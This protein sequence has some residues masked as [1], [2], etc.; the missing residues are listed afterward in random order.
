MR[1]LACL[2]FILLLSTISCAQLGNRYFHVDTL[3]VSTSARTTTYSQEWEF[4]TIYADTVDIM[5]KVGAPDIA[6]WASRD[7]FLV[8]QGMSLSIGPTPKLKK[9]SYY[10]TAGTGKIYV[11]GYKTTRQY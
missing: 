6:D 11:V 10:V 1:K 3:N 8:P 4:A 5:L 2:F 9:L 7:Y